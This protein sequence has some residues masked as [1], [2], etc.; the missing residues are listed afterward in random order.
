[1]KGPG[2]APILERL[3]SPV[4]AEAWREFLDAYAALILHV[5]RA[6][7]RAPDDA[8]ECF[9]YVCEELSRN[10]FRRLRRFRV[11]GPAAF[12]TWLSAVV[13]NLSID[14]HRR[15]SGRRRPF[16]AISRL[17]LLEQELFRCVFDQGMSA[18]AAL[19]HLKPRFPALSWARVSEGIERVRKALA[20]RQLWLLSIRQGSLVSIEQPTD[21]RPDAEAAAMSR[22][23]RAHLARALRELP[24]ADRLLLRL[25][26]GQDL[27]LEQIARLTGME[28]A[29]NVDRRIRKIVDELRRRMTGPALHA[30]SAKTERGVR[31][32]RTNDILSGPHG[33]DPV[34]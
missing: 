23:M 28:S 3:S 1:M 26:Y 25:R 7:E 31:V 20:P 30:E 5:I 10:G 9:L 18:D 19:L 13:R 17:P 24:R 11:D 2:V 4:A 22:E 16:R 12:P 14:W 29:Q 32:S 33:E 15:R 8:S 6:K 21:P 27:T 34:D